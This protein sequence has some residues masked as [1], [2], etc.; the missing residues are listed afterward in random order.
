MGY[1]TPEN[2]KYALI[3]ADDR[4]G[5]RIVNDS[6]CEILTY[7]MTNPADIFAVDYSMNERGN[8]FT[9]N[10]FDAVSEVQT[11]L[12]G[13]FNLYNCLAAAG[14]ARILG[15]EEEAILSGLKKVKMLR[16]ALIST[17]PERAV[18]LS[19][20]TRIRLTE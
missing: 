2:C 8:H 6:D 3:N 15:I 4:Y 18:K 20:T 19:S 1:F 11:G 10:L 13:K 14:A 7:G 17:A 5:A 12:Y 9:M 16:G